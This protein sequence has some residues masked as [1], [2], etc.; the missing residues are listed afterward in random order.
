MGSVLSGEADKVSLTKARRLCENAGRSWDDA[1]SAMF[2]AA[3]TDLLEALRAEEIAAL[4]PAPAA[5]EDVDVADAG[6]VPEA[7]PDEA[8]FGGGE[9][10][11]ALENDGDDGA[12]DDDEADPLTADGRPAADRDDRFAAEMKLLVMHEMEARMTVSDDFA[13]QQ[14]ER[15]SRLTERLAARAETRESRVAVNEEKQW[16]SKFAEY[17]AAKAAKLGEPRRPAASAKTSEPRPPQRADAPE[18]L[19]PRRPDAE[20]EGEARPRAGVV[21]TAPAAP[22]DAPDD[23]PIDA[24]IEAAIEAVGGEGVAVAKG[25]DREKRGS[26][27]KLHKVRDTLRILRAWLPKQRLR[28]AWALEGGASAYGDATSVR[29]AV[30]QRLRLSVDAEFVLCEVVRSPLDSS[31]ASV[32]GVRVVGTAGD[33]RDV[34][35][36]KSVWK[37]DAAPTP[38]PRS[39]GTPGSWDAAVAAVGGTRFPYALEFGPSATNPRSTYPGRPPSPHD[40][41]IRATLGWPLAPAAAGAYFTLAG[42]SRKQIS[43]ARHRLVAPSA[44]RGFYLL[45]RDVD[46]RRVAVGEVRAGAAYK[47]ARFYNTKA[48]L[49]SSDWL[50]DLSIA[51]AAKKRQPARVSTWPGFAV[52]VVSV[53]SATRVARGDDGTWV[54][55]ETRRE[56]TFAQLRVA[57]A[58][59]EQAPKGLEQ[60]LKQLL[61]STFPAVDDAD[62]RSVAATARVRAPPQTLACAL[63]HRL[64]L[65][66]GKHAWGAGSIGASG[67]VVGLDTRSGLY[68]FRVDNHGLRGGVPESSEAARSLC[69]GALGPEAFLLNPVLQRNATPAPSHAYVPGQ[70]LLVLDPATRLREDALVVSAAGGGR[71]AVV[72]FEDRDEDEPVDLNA[73]NHSVARMS[74]AHLV[75][76][77]REYARAVALENEFVEDAITGKHLHALRQTLH[78]GLAE[79]D[80]VGGVAAERYGDAR[81][82][83]DL[84]ALLTEP[85]QGDGS[86]GEAAA[87]PVLIMAEA[88]TGKSWMTKQIACAAAKAVQTGDPAGQFYPLVIYVQELAHLIRSRRDEVAEGSAFVHLV[89]AFIRIK[90]GDQP[91][92]CAALLQCFQQRTLCVIVDGIDEAA[93][94]KALIE[95]FIFR[96]IVPLGHR[97]LVTSRPEAI[98]AKRYAPSFVLLSLRKLDAEAQ[99]LAIR[100]Q[101]EDNEYFQRLA[102]FAEVRLRHDALWGHVPEDQQ[103][104][105]EKLASRDAFFLREGRR[106]PEARQRGLGGALVARRDAPAASATLRGLDDRLALLACARPP[107]GAAYDHRQ[108]WAD[109][110]VEELAAEAGGADGGGLWREIIAE[111]DELLAVA[112]RLRAPFRRA[113]EELAEALNL[114]KPSGRETDRVRLGPLKKPVRIYAKAHD[115]REGYEGYYDDGGLATANVV[116]VLRATLLFDD[117]P[118]RAP[119]PVR[120]GAPPER[121]VRA[122]SLVASFSSARVFRAREFFELAHHRP[123]RSPRAPRAGRRRPRARADEEQVRV[124]RSDAQPP[125]PLQR[126]R[127]REFGRRRAQPDRR[128]PAPPL[129]HRE[130]GQGEP[131]ARALRVLPPRAERRG[132]RVEPRGLPGQDHV[133]LREHLRD[134]RAPVAPHP[135][136][137][138]RGDARDADVR[139]RPL[140]AR[141]RRRAA[142]LRGRRRPPGRPRGPPKRRRGQ[143]P[144]EPGRRPGPHLRRAGALDRVERRRE[145]RRSYLRVQKRR[146]PRRCSRPRRA[147]TRGEEILL[148]S[149]KATTPSQVLSTALSGDATLVDAWDFMMRDGAPP[150]VKVIVSPDPAP[151]PGGV[152]HAHGGQF[153]FK[154][155]SLQEFFVAEDLRMALVNG[156]TH[157]A[158]T[159]D[160]PGWTNFLVARAF[161]QEYFKSTSR[162]HTTVPIGHLSNILAIAADL[163]DVSDLLLGGREVAIPVG[164]LDGGEPPH[165]FLILAGCRIGPRSLDLRGHGSGLKSTLKFV[166]RCAGL[167][168]LRLGGTSVCGT[169]RHLS[170]LGALRVLDLD[171]TL[172]Q[173]SLRP[174]EDCRALVELRIRDARLGLGPPKTRGVGAT[175]RR[176][177]ADLEPLVKLMNLEVVDLSRNALGGL[178]APLAA[179]H[180]LRFL[181]LSHTSVGGDVGG[182]EGLER[183]ED[184]HL[185]GCER[186]T[187]GFEVFGRLANLERLDLERTKIVGELAPLAGCA[188]LV[189]VNL[190]RL[191]PMLKGDISVLGG[192]GKLETL[193]IF[194]TVVEIPEGYAPRKLAADVEKATAAKTTKGLTGTAK[195]VGR[196]ED[197][198]A[199]RVTLLKVHVREAQHLIGRFEEGKRQNL[200]GAARFALVREKLKKRM[201]ALP[202][203]A[204]SNRSGRAPKDA[205]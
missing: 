63:G 205:D 148:A 189:H 168:E 54:D 49:R 165:L 57:A 99:A 131:R 141:G 110:T 117:A 82:S 33:S 162:V 193:A 147:A 83:S 64:R 75:S 93:D 80:G 15:R 171:G 184:L 58:S 11:D 122:R 52:D 166:S 200:N 89:E 103:E 17:Q 4:A 127:P 177:H 71:P 121:D 74:R 109:E 47:D 81:R 190:R 195:D 101:V 98:D 35:L 145:G 172:V 41:A 22:L 62:V 151:G 137:R 36:T 29:F 66:P 128:D 70:R 6:D 61:A 114:P 116:D 90:F 196:R 113:L 186:V 102:A 30:G 3:R 27:A 7:D 192:L 77:L 5:A 111:C 32:H 163:A 96:E 191:P 199:N 16:R 174:L 185:C 88:G 175:W 45:V 129:G 106:D 159:R 182:L 133:C 170:G 152:P 180:R 154:H 10:A 197:A 142:G 132:P 20:R 44:D 8:A 150:L 2:F 31:S 139:R 84:V 149:A 25:K 94:L 86:A 183:L 158:F 92:T 130:L 1:W 37:C 135:R 155:Q 87:Q 125:A 169:L 76:A 56:A 21:A 104:A 39:L 202:G 40:V 178:L 153:Q 203:T 100:Q 28:A 194:L 46:G 53:R 59:K 107:P 164:R 126:P 78:I 9:E 115:E 204:P 138:G 160:E 95:N 156:E 69:S 173:N 67:T 42:I 119:C 60:H 48:V 134:A 105:L 24:A 118:S 18:R 112:E 13:R 50:E 85:Q 176:V 97:L 146:R 144:A 108:E 68:A 26:F 23:V 34:D 201:M 198:N 181:N 140:P 167:E 51:Y 123:R 14:A 157:G 136:A 188:N 143:L 79:R 187:G 43:D 91:A 120:L 19:E 72:R 38:L 55:S 161:S 124:P 65:R 179:C 12:A 73:F